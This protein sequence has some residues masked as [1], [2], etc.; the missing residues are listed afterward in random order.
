MDIET[1]VT[2]LLLAPF[3]LMIVGMAVWAFQDIKADMEAAEEQAARER[4][5]R[6]SGPDYGE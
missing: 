1:I 3:I 4:R 5:F 2:G 6:E